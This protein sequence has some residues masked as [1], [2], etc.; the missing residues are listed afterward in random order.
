MRKIS[1]VCVSVFV[2]LTMLAPRLA[3]ADATSIGLLNLTGSIT[4]YDGSGINIGQLESGVPDSNHVFLSGQIAFTTNLV[5]GTTG[6]I[7]AHATQVAGV[8]VSTDTTFIGVAPG[9]HVYSVA[10]GTSGSDL[11]LVSNAFYLVNVQSVRVINQ[12]FGGSSI[13]NVVQGGTN[14]GARVSNDLGTSTWERGIDALVNTKKVVFVQ[15]AGNDGEAGDNTG[16]GAPNSIGSPGAA[17]NVI[18]VGAV[19][20]AGTA[21]ASYSS[22]GYLADGRSKPDIVAP[23]DN[24][25]M[26]TSPIGVNKDNTTANSGTSFATPQ[27]S[28]V[29]SRLLEA[30]DT[31]IT[32]SVYHDYATDS[33]TVKAVLLNSATKLAGW[34]QTGTTTNAGVINVVHPLDANQGAGLVNAGKAYDQFLGGTYE[35]ASLVGGRFG[36]M[37]TTNVPVNG[38]LDAL[39]WDFRGIGIGLTNSYQMANQAAGE[40]RLTLAWNRDVANDS[41]TNYPVLRLA[42]LNLL[43]WRSTDDAYTN[44]T[45]VAQS[46]SG[47]DNVQQLYFTDAAAGYYEF[48]V[49]YIGNTFAT[50]SYTTNAF[51]SVDYGVAWSFAAV[52]EP[53]A[54]FLVASGLAF[55]WWK[56]KRT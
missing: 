23:G 32:F 52:P 9:S 56:R 5:S 7:T 51:Q 15:A 39:G 34:T 44:L 28:A 8:M 30:A 40:I 46:V 33:R 31:N 11:A 25:T 2:I 45:L 3:L 22:R 24:I 47:V 6:T 42:D 37:T 10:Q 50:D 21:V 18:T 43:L 12:S 1:A 26:P 49:N 17:Y 13:T 20:N 54:L 48:G 19:N 55:L 36:D 16:A 4:A 35:V 14:F 41:D 29:V 27:V 38:K 53:S